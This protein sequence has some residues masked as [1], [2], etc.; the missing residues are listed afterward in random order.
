[1]R[2]IGFLLIAL[3]MVATPAS[4]GCSAED[5]INGKEGPSGTGGDNAEG[6][7]PDS[8]GGGSA[9]GIGNNYGQPQ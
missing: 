9:G 6:G 2:F 7:I 3:A 1:M 4:S 8:S 5:S